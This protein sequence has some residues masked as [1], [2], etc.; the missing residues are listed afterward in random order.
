MK[1]TYKFPF[2]GAFIAAQKVMPTL[3]TSTPVYAVFFSGL[4][5]YYVQVKNTHNGDVSDAP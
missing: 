2:T 5:K 4:D 3:T 1:A